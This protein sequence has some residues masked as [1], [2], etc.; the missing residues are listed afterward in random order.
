MQKILTKILIL[1]HFILAVIFQSC[2]EIIDDFEFKDKKEKI[3]VNGIMQSDSLFY[4]HISKS[5]PANAPDTLLP[6]TNADVKLYESGNLIE[7]LTFDKKGFYR[8]INPLNYSP[9]K[10]YKIRVEAKGL[11]SVEANALYPEKPNVLF[12]DTSRKNNDFYNYLNSLEFEIQFKDDPDQENFYMLEFKTYGKYIHEDFFNERFDTIIGFESPQLISDDEFIEIEYDGTGYWQSV[13][14]WETYGKKL[15]FSDKLING[16]TRSLKVQTESSYYYS[17]SQ[18]STVHVFFHSISKDYFKYMQR[19][20]LVNENE[21]NPLSEPVTIYSNIKNGLGIFG[22]KNTY[23]KS[24]TL[25]R[26]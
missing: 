16:K 1:A 25:I 12:I 24:F 8:T 11:K 17:N 20:A 19:R 3:V 14:E 15:V 5:I 21:G 26:R 22:A 4:V 13:P 18:D 23:A 10:S 2:E 6:I 7:D 9:S